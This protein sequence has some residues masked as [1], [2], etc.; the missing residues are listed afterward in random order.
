MPKLEILISCMNL[1]DNI[2][3]RSRINSDAV[4]INQCGR[5]GFIQRETE[6]K[7]VRIFSVNEKGLTKS[8]NLAIR[9]ASGDICLL[10]D[11]DECFCDG[12]ENGIL[13]AYGKLRDADVIAFK[14]KNIPE[15][16]G[17]KIK[18]LNRLDI[19]KISSWQISFR[20]KSILDAELEFDENMGAGTG[21]GAEEEFKFLSDCL[22]A[23]LKIYYCPFEIA[24]VKQSSSTWFKGYTKEFFVNRG[25]T[26]R[27]IMGLVPA[28]LYGLYYAFFKRKNFG[29]DITVLK[30]F[31]W[32]CEGIRENR[33]S[34]I[35][36]GRTEN[37]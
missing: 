6:E 13:N 7:L 17:G 11:D 31:F 21:N 32:I 26:T 28:V 37:E 12:Y 16:F 2:V 5:D 3:E 1:Q 4:I 19:M 14:T 18:R 15:K 34:K 25:V 23:G 10:C 30:A 24:D 8:R 36:K 20:R 22:D 29:N 35:K 33:L 9:K 27:Y